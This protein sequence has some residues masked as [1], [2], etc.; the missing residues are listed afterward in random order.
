MA[1]SIEVLY[2]RMAD[3][4]A[5]ECAQT[6]PLPYSCCDKM[7]CDEAARYAFEREGV[8]LQETGHAMLP[9]MGEHGCTVPPHLRPL[10]TVHTCAVNRFG[11]KPG[12]EAWTRKYFRLRRAI[13][14]AEWAKRKEQSSV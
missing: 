7:Y 4:T 8:V 2:Q 6:C 10:C 1:A 14:K 3:F 9:F 13:E 12:D 5:P 11:F